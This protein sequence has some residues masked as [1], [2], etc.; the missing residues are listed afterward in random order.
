MY[1]SDRKLVYIMKIENERYLIT[2]CE[3]GGEMESFLDKDTNTQYLY[4]GNTPFWGGKNPGLFPIIG[5]TF[6]G[7]YEIDETTY[8]MKNHGLIRYAQLSCI[9]HTDTS[10]TFEI[11]DNEETRA[12]YPFSFCYRVTYLLT[13]NK[14]D[15]TYD[16]MNTGDR[17]MP[18]SFGLHPSF[19]T[20]I[21]ENEC[22]ED[23]RLQFSNKETMQQLHY[24][25]YKEKPVIYEDIQIQDIPLTY[26]WILKEGTVIYKHC[27][28]AYV[29]LLGPKSYVKLSIA[30]YPYLAFWTPAKGAPFLCIEPWYGHDDFT[31]VKEDFYH[32]EG[33]LILSP[34]KTFTTSYSIEVG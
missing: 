9:A 19:L 15:I 5:S 8:T 17:D 13:N 14:V 3:K 26:D 16:I 23:Y 18:F 21:H 20:P 10:I 28:S 22:F 30:G 4:Q 29:T 7:S 34:R 27:K 6:C 11:C 2:F 31:D 32:R 33:T 1:N 12:Q 24:D 25:A